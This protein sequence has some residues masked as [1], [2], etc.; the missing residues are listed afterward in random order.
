M[1]AITNISECMDDNTRTY[2]D[3]LDDYIVE[4]MI[5]KGT[6]G[7]VYEGIHKPNNQN[8]AIKII[9]FEKLKETKNGMSRIKTEIEVQSKLNHDGI[10]KLY[11]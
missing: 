5:G 6:F 4:D 7:C 3:K 11:Q 10:I 2:S 1:S 8:V 9:E